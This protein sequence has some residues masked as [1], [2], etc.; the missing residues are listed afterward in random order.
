MALELAPDRLEDEVTRRRLDLLCYQRHR[1]VLLCRRCHHLPLKRCQV[2]VEVVAHLE[3]RQRQSQLEQRPLRVA[4]ARH[5]LQPLGP[6]LVAEAVRRLKCES[7]VT[8][9]APQ[10]HLLIELRRV[11]HQVPNLHL[12]HE[13]VEPTR[14]RHDAAIRGLREDLAVDLLERLAV[15][16]QRC[17]VRRAG[18]GQRHDAVLGKYLVSLFPMACE[19]LQPWQL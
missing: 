13:T 3:Q 4:A 15:V 18:P 1:L 7:V 5:T 6:P 17:Q 11:R 12:V 19:N 14:A 10:V 8:L 9:D 2:L 16:R